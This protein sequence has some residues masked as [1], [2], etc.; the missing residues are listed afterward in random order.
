MLYKDKKTKQTLE[1][2]L[3]KATVKEKKSSCKIEFTRVMWQ[4]GK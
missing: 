2:A 1:S 4:H 3:E